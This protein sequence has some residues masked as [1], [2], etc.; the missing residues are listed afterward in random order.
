[1]TGWKI[2]IGNKFSKPMI[3]REM[4][5]KIWK[6][7]IIQWENIAS[8]KIFQHFPCMKL[9]SSL[10]LFTGINTSANYT[11][12]F[13]IMIGWKKIGNLLGKWY[14]VKWWQKFTLKKVFSNEKNCFKKDL[15]ALSLPEF[16]Y[17]HIIFNKKWYSFSCSIWN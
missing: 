17:V 2:I 13:W 16:F 4:I 6:K 3:S 9:F 7:I 12:Y 1:M 14:H 10:Y 11:S 5:A 15:Q 8:R